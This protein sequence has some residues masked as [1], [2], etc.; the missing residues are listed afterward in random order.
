MIHSCQPSAKQKNWGHLLKVI[1][2]N[3]NGKHVVEI[4]YTSIVSDYALLRSQ[5]RLDD[6]MTGSMPRRNVSMISN[7]FL[8]WCHSIFHKSFLTLWCSVGSCQTSLVVHRFFRM[9]CEICWTRGPQE[10]RRVDL[11]TVSE[12]CGDPK[13]AE[14]P[15]E[16]HMISFWQI[17]L[18]Q[19]SSLNLDFI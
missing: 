11:L 14:T 1:K 3:F 4:A 10:G 18:E 15:P 12:D 6:W 17:A 2:R 16:G 13:Q 8:L 9:V 19:T 5:I 7:S